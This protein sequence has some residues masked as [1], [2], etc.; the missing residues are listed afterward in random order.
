MFM[1]I[2]TSQVLAEEENVTFDDGEELF[3]MSIEQLM[4]IEVESPATLT[5]TV[6]RLIPA[7]VTTITQEQ[8]KTSGARSLNELLDIY[9][10]NLQ[11]ILHHWEARH[12]GLRGIISDREEKY[13][14][15]VNNRIMNER[16]HYGALSERDFPMLSDI[17][18]ID[19]V[20]GP[21]SAIYGPGAVSMVINIVTDNAMTF[22]GTEI[23]GRLGAFEE[24]YS[25]EVKHG[26]KLDDDSGLLL[27]FGIDDY[28]GADQDDAPFVMGT[29][30]NTYW[31][32]SVRKGKGVDYTINPYNQAFREKNR[33]KTHIQYNDGPLDI[34][35]RYTR[36]GETF[37]YSQSNIANG[38][39]GWL[40]DAWAL[41][42]WDN[43]NNYKQPGTGYQQLTFYTGYTQEISDIFMVD[44]VFSYDTFS[45]VRTSFDSDTSS[46]WNLS[47][48]E[49]EYLTRAIAH[50]NI[51]TH[52]SVAFGGEWSHEE[53]GLSSWGFPHDHAHLAPYSQPPHNGN[54]PRWSTD[55]FSAMGEHQWKVNKKWTTFIG[56]RIDKCECTD[57]LFSPRLNVIY[58]PD[59]INTWK[60][61]LSESLRMTFA[62]EMRWKWE[63]STK[64]SGPEKLKSIE[65]RYERQHTPNLLFGIS[66]YFHDLDVIAWNPGAW[67]VEFDAGTKHVGELQ[68]YGAEAE[69]TYKKGNAIIT[70][71]HGY[72]KLANYHLNP[73]SNTLMTAEPYGYGDDLANWSNHITKIITGYEITDLWRIDASARIYWGFPGA[74]DYAQYVTNSRNPISRDPGYDRPYGPSIFVNFGVQH[75]PCKHVTIRVVGYDLLGLIDDKY[76]KRL[77]GF[78]EY[79]DYRASSPAVGISAVYEN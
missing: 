68:Q 60:L 31:G 55:T 51:N 49:D 24:F 67:G 71:S 40:D 66:T 38:N 69:M 76:N 33:I 17:H 62:E 1:L 22:Q 39:Y 19:V 29:S 72:T 44:Y 8:I 15:L 70:V 9:V 35:A 30:F 5:K 65:L 54:S 59:E 12:L 77:Y 61:M 74:K 43:Y 25:T 3:E 23:T 6:H 50:W 73:G 53:F 63:H 20:R 18:H 64:K 34:W 79:S 41:G 46:I 10:P 78:N 42:T 48:R 11:M 13:L 52:H 37:T 32:D 4:D 7:A 36:G 45:Y 14:L 58:T 16:T 21:G 75:K 26:V 2:C 28:L 57:Y 56:C 27:Y 47:H